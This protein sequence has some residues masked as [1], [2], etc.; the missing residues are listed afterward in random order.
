M[1]ALLL[2]LLLWQVADVAPDAEQQYFHYERAVSLPSTAADGGQACATLDGQVYAHAATSLKDVR[3]YQ[4]MRE[5]PYAITLS[6]STEADS[7][8]AKVLNLGMRGKKIVFDLAMPARPYTDVVL[9]LDAH[10]FI[11]SAEVSAGATKLGTFTLFD[12]SSQRLSRSMTLRLQES[13]FS[14][15]HV[16]LNISSADGSSAFAAT[17][18]MV[19]GAM[20]PPNREAQTVYTVVG[21]TAAVTQRGRQTVARFLLPAH[22]PVERVS[23]AMAPGFAGNFS[24][25]VEVTGRTEGAPDAAVETLTGSI[26]RVRMERAGGTIRQEQLSVPATLGANLQKDA[27]VEVLIDNGNDVPLPVSSV[28]L[29]MRE[30]RLCFAVP[31]VDGLRLFYGDDKLDAPVYDYARLFSQ[32]GKVATAALKAEESNPQYVGR[33]VPLRPLT[34]R[35]PELLWVVLLAVVCVLAVVAMHSAKRMPK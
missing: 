22:V 34:E 15:L 29:E 8:P 26:L 24:R 20:V 11:A 23:F 6:E 18:A 13:S 4:G 9:D 25:N 12:L 5:V 3:L 28:R 19:E 32:D 30:R 27:T 1:K 21:E 31:A 17:T 33:P 14:T 35:Y 16:E 7:E 10:D 2:A